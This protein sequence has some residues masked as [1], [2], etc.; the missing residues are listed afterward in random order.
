MIQLSEEQKKEA[1]E[2]VKRFENYCRSNSPIF[3]SHMLREVE[4]AK[5][6]LEDG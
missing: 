6:V 5:E 2:T 4:E 1:A 3:T